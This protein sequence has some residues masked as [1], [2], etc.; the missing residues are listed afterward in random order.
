MRN[1]PRLLGTRLFAG[2]KFPLAAV[3]FLLFF[4]PQLAMAS[5]KPCQSSAVNHSQPYC[6]GVGPSGSGYCQSGD[7]LPAGCQFDGISNGIHQYSCSCGSGGCTMW[8]GTTLFVNNSIKPA[9]ITINGG[10]TL[11]NSC[12]NGNEDT[13]VPSALRV[14]VKGDLNLGQNVDIAANID[15]DGS[16]TAN[17]QAS[18]IQIWGNLAA[19]SNIDFWEYSSGMQ[20]HGNVSSLDNFVKLTGTVYGNVSAGLGHYVNLIQAHVTG[21]VDSKQADRTNCLD[22][23]SKVDGCFTVHSPEAIGA[24]TYICKNRLISPKENTYDGS[25]GS[26][27]APA[28]A[29]IGGICCLRHGACM[30]DPSI[31]LAQTDSLK[32]AA[33]SGVKSCNVHPASV[34][35]SVDNANPKAGQSVTFTIVAQPNPADELDSLRVEDILPPGLSYQSATADIG[36]TSYDDSTRKFIW[37]FSKSNAPTGTLKLKAKVSCTQSNQITNV[38]TLYNYISA[39]ASDN[40]TGADQLDQLDQSSASLAVQGPCGELAAS[41]LPTRI[42]GQGFSIGIDSI[43]GNGDNT[44][45]STTGTADVALLPASGL[46]QSACAALDSPPSSALATATADFG[47]TGSASANAAFTVNAISPA[48]RVW[49]RMQGGTQSFCSADT[50]AIRPANFFLSA[51]NATGPLG[52]TNPD[53]GSPAA[54][55]GSS[56]T[57]KAAALSATGTALA[58][59][60]G[61]PQIDKGKLS[62]TGSLGGGTVPTP[63]LSWASASAFS[64]AQSG[65]ATGNGFRYL[66]AGTFAL[67]SAAVY[68]ST[69][70]AID[71]SQGGKCIAGSAS[72]TP[73]GSGLVGCNFANQAAYTVGRWHPASFAFSGAISPPCQGSGFIY[74]GQPF[75]VALSITALAADGATA[76]PHYGGNLGKVGQSNLGGTNVA[77]FYAENA[78]SNLGLAGSSRTAWA[79]RLSAL[80]CTW[81]AGSC[82]A[83]AQPSFAKAA[84]PDGPYGNFT[85]MARLADPDG[86]AFATGSATAATNSER[87]LRG[88][89]WAEN[90][91]GPIGFSLPV[92][93]AVRYWAGSGWLRNPADTCTA[94]AL[95]TIQNGGLDDAKLNAKWRN[96]ES[97]PAVKHPEAG[98]AMLELVG[99]QDGHSSLKLAP[100]RDSAVE[101]SWLDLA[102]NALL[103]FGRCGPRHSFIWEKE[104]VTR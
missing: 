35:K 60:T 34:K 73:N 96:P 58:A 69:Y 3:A 31:C 36:S 20:I 32:Q 94:L 63:P 13:G 81:S 104:H 5:S 97:T 89:L 47:T 4:L 93:F 75:G 7:K 54:A 16:T 88:Q 21:D 79:S 19:N 6:L 41:S 39:S 12:I 23:T 22:A 57:L 48:V 59:Y 72:N 52:N 17:D 76:T 46:S 44:P 43:A 87:M 26:I 95:P 50:F 80:D 15:V 92:P 83:N 71:Q 78:G 45:L 77:A 99:G 56:F 70:T 101:Q 66:D 84:K 33:L 55:A 49:M 74:M 62:G 40:T 85:V 38:A 27:R 14:H 37:I 61:S 25:V 91:Y 29:S 68:D 98:S 100:V 53:S 90:A 30:S 64:A 9:E 11:S 51:S 102:D 42:A 2:L 86:I 65:I 103:C 1:H 28:S 67:G 8:E 18:D 10:L 82:T 24:N